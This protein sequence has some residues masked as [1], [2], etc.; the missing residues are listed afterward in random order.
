[1]GQ[2]VALYRTKFLEGILHLFILEYFRKWLIFRFAF[3]MHIAGASIPTRCEFKTDIRS[4]CSCQ[5]IPDVSAPGQQCW[6]VDCWKG[7]HPFGKVN[8][9]VIQNVFLFI[10]DTTIG[11][12]LQGNS[13]HLSQS[14]MM[15]KMKNPF[16]TTLS[17]NNSMF[18]AHSILTLGTGCLTKLIITAVSPF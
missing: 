3:C 2:Q 15:V 14:Q 7:K 8:L 4:C 1:M 11:Y 12:I 16:H 10:V 5:V 9:P 18:L 13:K 17:D 6:T